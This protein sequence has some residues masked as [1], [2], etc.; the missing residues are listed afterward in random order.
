ML[1]GQRSKWVGFIVSL[2]AGGGPKISGGMLC[3][4][5][6][7][8]AIRARNSGESGFCFMRMR[9]RGDSYEGFCIRGAATVESRLFHI[10]GVKISR[11]SCPVVY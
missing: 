11:V 6:N 5:L 2:I 3:M 9:C 8:L 10:G 4:L 7:N 1:F